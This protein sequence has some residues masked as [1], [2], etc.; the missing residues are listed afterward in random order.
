MGSYI[1]DTTAALLSISN[2]DSVWITANVPEHLV[3]VI[4]QGQRVTID[5]PAYPNLVWHGKVAFVNAFLDPDTRRNQTRIAMPNPGG[6]LQPN[7]Y[8]TVRVSVPQSHFVMIPISAVLMN[9]DTTSVYV[10][11]APWTFQR[12]VVQLGA[13]D[14]HDV[15]VVSGLKPGERIAAS[16]GIFIN[17]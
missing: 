17:D 1:N 13:E 4:T 7:M 5:L 8:A 11:T 10:E 9:D 6:K 12:R 2:I 16:G 3:G 14:G 15:R